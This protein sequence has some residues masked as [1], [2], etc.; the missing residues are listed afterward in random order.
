MS[1]VPN[2]KICRL[3]P[4]PFLGGRQVCERDAPF[5]NSNRRLRRRRRRCRE[6][7]FADGEFFAQTVWDGE[8]GTT[9]WPAGRRA[10]SSAAA[11]SARCPRSKIRPDLEGRASQ[12]PSA[13][14]TSPESHSPLKSAHYQSQ[15]VSSVY[16][17][18]VYCPSKPTTHAEADNT[19]ANMKYGKRLGT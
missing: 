15:S 8:R 19:T 1:Q 6:R 5:S 7:S 9:A 3:R 18:S 4:P 14:A 12:G 2:S 10:G 11:K 16:F 13:S 17:K